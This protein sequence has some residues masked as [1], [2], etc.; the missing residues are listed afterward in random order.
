MKKIGKLFLVITLASTLLG[1]FDTRRGGD[2]SLMRDVK[3][4]TY[5]LSEQTKKEIEE[6]KDKIII[7]EFFY[8]ERSTSMTED[9]V[10]TSI[11]ET[12]NAI[13][14]KMEENGYTIISLDT[15]TQGEESR[16]ISFIAIFS[17]K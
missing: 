1:C 10:T 2:R 16:A 11:V 6:G 9:F 12:V 3:T 7:A 13:S 8:R 14:E 5:E 17:K 15:T 4:T